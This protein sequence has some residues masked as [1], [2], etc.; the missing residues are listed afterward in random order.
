MPLHTSKQKVD[1]PHSTYIVRIPGYPLARFYGETVDKK[2]HFSKE[3]MT[4]MMK[5]KASQHARFSADSIIT[6]RCRQEGEALKDN[7]RRTDR[8]A[9]QA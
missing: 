4:C 8:R 9:E 5:V 3:H 6:L 7:I 2:Y 1:S